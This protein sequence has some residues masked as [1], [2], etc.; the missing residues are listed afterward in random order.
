MSN[1]DRG[2]GSAP[3]AGRPA[4]PLA[5]AVYEPVAERERLFCPHCDYN[6]TGLVLNRCPEC[7]EH[8][9]RALLRGLGSDMVR[10][11]VPWDRE[12]GIAW[13]FGTLWMSLVS[14]RQMAATFPGRHSGVRAS[15]YGA[16]CLALGA[17]LYCLPG[18]LLG[19]GFGRASALIAIGLACAVV[20]L[21]SAI[22]GLLS[23][24]VPP[25]V[26]PNPFLFWRGLMFYMR[27]YWVV[28]AL[29]VFPVVFD[30]SRHVVA[31]SLWDRIETL[32]RYTVPVVGVFLWWWL[33]WIGM[34]VKRSRPAPQR[35]VALGLI[36]FGAFGGLCV[37]SVASLLA[38]LV[39]SWAIRTWA[40]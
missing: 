19:R 27:G 17:V 20:V 38:W 28:A 36:P 12:G 3:E 15:T 11:A 7:G 23:R 37:G 1:E 18:L 39:M 13:F 10:P 34:V 16:V 24:T 32:L 40:G 31:W 30:A 33:V 22:V 29:V 35:T 9:D 21:E 6:L 8:F 2:T 5:R 26:S 14:P 25:T 4:V